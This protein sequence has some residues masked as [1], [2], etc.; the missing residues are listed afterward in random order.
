MKEYFV[1]DGDDDYK[2]WTQWRSGKWEPKTKE[3]IERYVSNGTYVDIGAWIGPTVIWASS[4]ASRVI[5]IEPDPTAFDLLNKNVS[6]LSNVETY[7]LAVYN[8][9]G[10]TTIQ[11]SG[12]SMSRTGHG[13]A[14]IQCLTLET[15]FKALEISDID[16]IKIDI[17]GAE[18]EVLEHAEPFLRSLG[19]PVFLSYHSWAPWEYDLLENWNLEVIETS[20]WLI[21]PK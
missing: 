1:N 9:D 12:N 13:S 6:D 21:I 3:V 14:K 8:Y 4:L 17:E 18:K 2:F 10:E 15:L 20:E 11:S 7:N 5:A 19:V 16:L